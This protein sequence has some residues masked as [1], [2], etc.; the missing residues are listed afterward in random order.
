MKRWHQ[1]ESPDK[2]ILNYEKKFQFQKLRKLTKKMLKI[3]KKKSEELSKSRRNAAKGK[4]MCLKNQK[5]QKMQK[6]VV[7]PEGSKIPCLP[8]TTSPCGLP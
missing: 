5:M 1:M 6:N 2:I 7:P 8:K 4:K 3:A